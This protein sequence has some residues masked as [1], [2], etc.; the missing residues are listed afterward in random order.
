MLSVFCTT[1]VVVPEEVRFPSVSFCRMFPIG[2]HP[3]FIFWCYPMSIPSLALFL[4][5]QHD[6]VPNG[7]RFENELWYEYVFSGVATL[8]SRLTMESDLCMPRDQSRC[9]A[10]LRRM[11]GGRWPL[12]PITSRRNICVCGV[13]CLMPSNLDT[14]LYLAVC[15]IAL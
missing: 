8:R 3:T 7:D 14:A 12:H 6:P 13:A 11:L 9:S 10:P 4:E 5:R 2:T 1:G 15:S